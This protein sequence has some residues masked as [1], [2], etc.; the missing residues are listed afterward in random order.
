[1]V[2]HTFTKTVHSPPFQYI[3]TLCFQHRNNNATI[4]NYLRQICTSGAPS[5]SISFNTIIRITQIYKLS[6]FLFLLH[7]VSPVNMI[8]YKSLSSRSLTLIMATLIHTKLI[9]TC[10]ATNYFCTNTHKTVVKHHR[11]QLQKSHSLPPSTPP[12]HTQA[13]RNRPS[14]HL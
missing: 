6:I 3:V 10:I 8:L 9:H 5:T 1:M 2:F 13:Q 11:Q 4:L 7:I 12:Q 14:C